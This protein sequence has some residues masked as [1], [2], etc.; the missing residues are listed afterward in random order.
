M[1]VTDMKIDGFK[2]RVG[3]FC[4]SLLLLL[5][6]QGCASIHCE[7]PVPHETAT[8]QAQDDMT[9]AMKKGVIKVISWNVHGLSFKAQPRLHRITREL[10]ARKPDVIVLQEVWFEKDAKFLTTELISEYQRVQD[11]SGIKLFGFFRQ[12]G[13][14][15]FLHKDHALNKGNHRPVF[16]PFIHSA[17]SFKIL[18]GDGFSGKGVQFFQFSYHGKQI[19]LFNTHLQSQYRT[20]DYSDIRK[21]QIN[22]LLNETRTRTQQ[23]AIQLIFGDFNTK[24]DEGLYVTMTTGW[25]DLTQGLRVNCSNCGTHLE[26]VCGDTI[27]AKQWLDYGLINQH[28]DATLVGVPNLIKSTGIDCPFSDHYGLEY[29]L[30]VDAAD[31]IRGR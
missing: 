24:P 15:A 26:K 31:V 9:N 11:S 2:M 8:R 16:R 14:L 18:E 12:G 19:Q 13:L 7:Y 29:E 20:D 17:P 5:T 1:N 28:A 6:L 3:T 4:C 21:E 23:G 27:V 22:E 25:T 10:L 30:S